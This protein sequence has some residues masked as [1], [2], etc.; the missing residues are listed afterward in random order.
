MKSKIILIIISIFFSISAS[1]QEELPD[2]YLPI[3]FKIKNNK[4]IG[5][6]E[7]LSGFIFSMDLKSDTLIEIPEKDDL[8]SII[9]NKKI[10]G[11]LRYPNN[12]ITD[13]DY[14]IVT[15]RGFEDIYM[16]STLGYFIWEML[17]IKKDEISIAIYWW[18]CPPASKT[19]LEI[20]N[21]TD[22]LLSDPNN[23]H[24]NDDRKCENDIEN[25]SWSLFCALK[26]AS[27]E[28]A[29]EYNHH[30]TA[31]QTA[32]FVIDDMQ[33]NHNYEHTLM[34]FNNNPTISHKEIIKV[35]EESKK[36]IKKELE[37]IKNKK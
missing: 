5:V 2:N 19:D 25:N 16:K 10:K 26:H 37:N 23:W 8:F 11:T 34:D 12:R 21:M 13:I 6:C 33:A 27:I 18:Y 9:K 22:S 29:K 31:V 17:D 35:I 1:G 14:E 7:F 28:K 36:R 20:L 24:Q 15:H 32:R 3:S 30:N 4:L